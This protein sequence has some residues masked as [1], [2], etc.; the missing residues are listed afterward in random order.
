MSLAAVATVSFSLAKLVLRMIDHEVVADMIADVEP[1]G[2]ILMRL[3]RRGAARSLAKEL[4]DGIS[5][6]GA[7]SLA[8]HDRR[9][10]LEAVDQLLSQIGDQLAVQRLVT[11]DVWPWVLEHGGHFHKVDL[12][13]GSGDYFERVLRHCVDELANRVPG[14]GFP[15]AADAH[16][17]T[18]VDALKRQ[19]DDLNRS[20]KTALGLLLTNQPHR[21]DALSRIQAASVSY[22]R[23]LALAEGQYVGRTIEGSL[24]DGIIASS[25][26]WP[27]VIVGE[28]G[29][30]KST[31][32]WSL[33]RELDRAGY[34]P[35]LTSAAWLMAH[36]QRVDD[37]ASAAGLVQAAGAPI[38]LIDTVDLMLHQEEE[39]QTLLALMEQLQS[40]DIPAIYTTRPQER[41]L[42]H[43]PELRETELGPYSEREMRDAT[44][45]LVAEY[46]P[47][48]APERV[49]LDVSRS[50]ARGLP[51]AD[52]CRSPLLL[53]MLFETS[54]QAG[55]EFADLDVTTLYGAYWTR[56]VERDVRSDDA[57]S[58]RASQQDDLS[59]VAGT[60]AAALLVLGLPLERE[61]RVRSIIECLEPSSASPAVVK[62]GIQRLRERGVLDEAPDEVSFFHQTMF[63]YAFARWWLAHPHGEVLDRLV[64]GTAAGYGDLFVG[65]ALEQTLVLA[66]RE[67]LLV[68]KVKVACQRLAEDGSGSVQ[69]IG[70][71]IWAQRPWALHTAPPVLARCDDAALIRTARLLPSAGGKSVGEVVSQLLVL[72]EAKDSVA[73]RIAVLQAL[74][75]VA[76][77]DPDTVVMALDHLYPSGA[78]TVDA[79]PEEDP[80]GPEPEA[81]RGARAITVEPADQLVTAFLDLFDGLPA[82]HATVVRRLCVTLLRGDDQARRAIMGFLLDH[83]QGLG[84]DDLLR[85]VLHA[86]GYPDIPTGQL[87]RCGRL[88]AGGVG[89]QIDV[90]ALL[91][92]EGESFG[93]GIDMFAL[94]TTAEMVDEDKLEPLV[95][96][97]VGE[98]GDQ[99]AVSRMGLQS[100]LRSR[101][102]ATELVARMASRAL[103]ELRAGGLS[104]QGTDILDY[105]VHQQQ[106]GSVYRQAFASMTV[107]EWLAISELSPVLIRAAASGVPSAEKALEGIAR[108][109]ERLEAREVGA[110]LSSIT[111]TVSASDKV[112]DQALRVALAHE[113]TTVLARLLS[114]PKLTQKRWD[115]I[116]DRLLQQ[117]NCA[118]TA[119]P[120]VQRTLGS[121]SV[122]VLL[123]RGEFVS[124][125]DASAA[126]D[127][128][129]DRLRSAILRSLWKRKESVDIDRDRI[130]HLLTI[131]SVNSH[132][133]VPVDRV[134]PEDSAEILNCAAQSLHYISALQSPAS[135]ENWELV[136]TLSLFQPL[137]AEPYVLGQSLAVACRYLENLGGQRNPTMPHMMLDL[138]EQMQDVPFIGITPT[139]W[140]RELVNAANCAV[141]I[142]GADLAIQMSRL[143]AQL[144]PDVAK[145]LLVG[146]ADRWFP[147]VR[148][149]LIILGNSLDDHELRTL[150]QGLVRERD[151]S[152]GTRSFPEVIPGRAERLRQML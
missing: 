93:P 122:H 86:V 129:D 17:V 76:L 88:V 98:R 26:P 55:P 52:V 139:L 61:I 8:D 85:E 11:D 15:V 64:E 6:V 113:Q 68:E 30:G 104:S 152:N 83:W 102:A 22:R 40:A 59:A 62:E 115:A 141:D 150:C 82:K 79:A 118:S 24:L 123:N 33:E 99:R 134:N 101:P 111:A 125:E 116:H 77:N 84:S 87:E 5:S 67:R 51:A 106:P 37:L 132:A 105:L 147:V 54:G 16:L 91:T 148:E 36:P 41:P 120:E 75:R 151:R 96:R 126:L 127:G 110:I 45:A 25:R 13:R 9:A 73:P 142:G 27:R 69:A 47:S 74:A 7:E 14:A 23:E 92:G 32:L 12:G 44:A 133:E 94:A 97:L 29:A 95:C 137:H 63:E 131:V 71:A 138:L 1:A 130:A 49:A 140:E 56:R 35:I 57:A 78:V 10:A 107:D 43:H 90:A 39:R 146:L 100:L 103:G 109:P 119:G 19:L 143:S 124:W 38:I 80:S 42:I 108:N 149:S 114:D 4:E 60:T 70:L 2:R 144:N 112:F 50:V 34:D 18:E 46:C 135:A 48:A 72:W 3:R 145:V 21:Q 65:A 31:L 89:S 81:V 121:L 117:I 128:A 136:R 58:I 66:A 20:V 53:R 28:A